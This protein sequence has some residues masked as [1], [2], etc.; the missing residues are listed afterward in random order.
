MKLVLNMK[1]A[2]FS[3]SQEK[4]KKSKMSEVDNDR[5]LNCQKM[6]LNFFCHY[7]GKNYLYILRFQ[8]SV[9]PT[10]FYEDAYQLHM[11]S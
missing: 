6:T 9:A 3:P 10:V 2:H 1:C 8:I 4:I 5:K 11:L 7:K